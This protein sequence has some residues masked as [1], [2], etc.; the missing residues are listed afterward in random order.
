MAKKR[1]SERSSD[2]RPRSSYV[3]KNPLKRKASLDNL[4]KRWSPEARA[5]YEAK[6]GPKP[7][8]VDVKKYKG[9]VKKLC[10]FAADP[11][12]LIEDYFYVAEGRRLI[13]L[14][15]FQ[16]ET[17]T[18]LF[19]GKV[20]P[21]MAVL[22]QPKKTGKSTFAAAVALYYLLTKD[23]A[24]IYLLAS[25]AS[26]S[27]LVCFDK[28]VKCIRINPVL[29][30]SCRILTTAGRIEFGDSFVMILAPNVS[31]AGV[32]PSLIIGE[33]LWSWVQPEH[34]RA[35]DE[36]C[37]VPTRED[38]LILVTSYAGYLEDEK[39]ILWRLYKQGIDQAEGREEIDP[40]LWF[41][42]HG[43]ELYD[44]VPWVDDKYLPQQKKRLRENA[45]LRLHENK[46]ASGEENFCDVVVLD[47]CTNPDLKRGA[48]FDG[49]VTVGIDIGLKH[50]TS[51]VVVVGMV[52]R[53]TLATVDHRCFTPLAGQTLDL[54][55]TVEAVMLGFH[56]K[57]EIAAVFYD[58][59]QFARSAR[60]LE[61][62]GL[63][64]A[65]YPQT[66]GNTVAMSEALSGLLNNQNLMLYEDAEL[67]EHLLNAKA[68]ETQR[69]WRL[70]KKG[71]AKKIDLSIALAE[72]V[73]A[74]QEKLLLRNE[75]LFCV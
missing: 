16:K 62:A 67:R 57:Y 5:K 29:R 60:T 20:K 14:M 70:V 31:V 13:E 11:I 27:Q 30:D 42:W 6:D 68:R 56:K 1:S 58:P 8:G 52:D 19:Y 10:D 26:Q 44:Q 50:D 9:K 43:V 2:Y 40:R 38:N 46:W 37:N 45:Y 65:E 61:K 7:L 41:K 66:A 64:M 39:S 21:N 15:P 33:E 23:M 53:E 75:C 4:K 12:G 47:A 17:L 69:G 54:E 18:D 25:T 36:L 32:N 49:P 28:L 48:P 24:E 51:A 59:F 22:G 72:A 35:W 73:K 55:H 74:A 34:V 3:S 71:R 63:P